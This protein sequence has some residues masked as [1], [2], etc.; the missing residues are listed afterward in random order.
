MDRSPA[1]TAAELARGAARM[2]GA[3]WGLA[4]T[5]VAGPDPQDGHPVGQV[6]VAVAGERRTQVRELSLAGDR[7]EIRAQTVV[8]VL[9]P[10]DRTARSIRGARRR[11][12]PR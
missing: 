3:D 4:T 6:F 1:T 12:R 8:A 9:T 7:S 10:A 11:V 2:C 5:G